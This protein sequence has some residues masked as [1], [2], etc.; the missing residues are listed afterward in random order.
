MR[1]SWLVCLAVGLVVQLVGMAAAAEKARVVP[2]RIG[3]DNDY[4]DSEG[5]LAMDGDPATIWH[6]RASGGKKWSS[7]HPHQIVLDLGEP[8]EI[9]GFT[10]LP[11]SNGGNGTIANY[12][13]YVTDDPKDLG[14][15]AAKGTFAKNSEEKTVTLPEKKQGRYACLVTPGAAEEVAAGHPPAGMKLPEDDRVKSLGRVNDRQRTAAALG[16]IGQLY[17]GDQRFICDHAQA[18]FLCRFCR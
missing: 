13:F 16:E 9:G 10:Y 11:R 14:P 12:E 1:T 17:P 6:T 2:V 15:P 18:R 4:I 8:F 5:V 7:P 3:V